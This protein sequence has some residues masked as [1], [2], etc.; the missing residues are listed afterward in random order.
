LEFL[1]DQELKNIHKP[2]LI[3][4][5][6]MERD[7]KQHLGY[8]HPNPLENRIPH[9]SKEWEISMLAIW[10]PREGKLLIPLEN[11]PIICHMRG[12]TW[13]PPPSGFM[14]LNFDRASRGNLGL[15]GV[16][17][18]FRDAQG[19][20]IIMYIVRLGHT[21]NNGEEMEGLLE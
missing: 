15:G 12:V 20:I 13:D 14:K 5:P 1:E 17:G 21:T 11:N 19:E 10:S 7:H 4:G 2:G 8:H 6:T 9:A 16:G 18:I 3:T